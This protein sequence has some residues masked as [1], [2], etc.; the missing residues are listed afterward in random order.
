MHSQNTITSDDHLHIDIIAN[1]SNRQFWTIYFII[2]YRK[3]TVINYLIH[4]MHIWPP[5]YLDTMQFNFGSQFEWLVL[6]NYFQLTEF[7]FS[8][9]AY[10]IQTDYAVKQNSPK[11][12]SYMILITLLNVR[13]KREVKIQ[14]C[15]NLFEKPC[16]SI[17]KTQCEYRRINSDFR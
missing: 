12:Q 15:I 7:P 16:V 6:I 3:M 4:S 2:K 1:F 5:M 13:S 17:V 8:E 10:I 14:Q 11:Q 9:Q